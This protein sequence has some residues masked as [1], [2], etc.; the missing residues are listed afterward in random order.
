LVHFDRFVIAMADVMA[1]ADN[2]AVRTEGQSMFEGHGM[3]EH[4][5]K[6]KI[7]TGWVAKYDD[8]Q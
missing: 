3:P 1:K 4:S 8:P 2:R 6:I 5:F 7:L